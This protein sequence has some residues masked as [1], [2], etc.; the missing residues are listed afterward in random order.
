MRRRE[1]I[2]LA[3][4]M[5]SALHSRL[6]GEG[7]DNNDAQIVANAIAPMI[8]QQ[9]LQGGDPADPAFQ[10]A[11][12]SRSCCDSDPTFAVSC[13]MLSRLF[14]V[15]GLLRFNASTVSVRRSA[16]RTDPCRRRRPAARL[17][18]VQ[19]SA[20]PR[21]GGAKIGPAPSSHIGG[22]RHR[23]A[24]ADQDYRADLVGVMARR[25]VAQ[26]RPKN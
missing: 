9:R 14:C 23:R 26:K 8:A 21:R 22:M 15:I 3:G 5:A 12:T 18:Q 17:A 6:S 7:I 13:R 11:I 20:Q 1:F 4:Q 24:S 2:M 10:Q 25:A 16:A 19:E